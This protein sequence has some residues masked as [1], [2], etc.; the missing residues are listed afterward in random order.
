MA[1][2]QM[3]LTIDQLKQL[4]D[5]I[6][7]TDEG[8]L[9]VMNA[10][11][12]EVDQVSAM[13]SSFD[14]TMSKVASR[15]LGDI[16]S[17]KKA[18]D[19]FNKNQMKFQKEQYDLMK[20]IEKLQQIG[21]DE[22]ANAIVQ[23]RR[24]LDNLLN[25]SKQALEIEKKAYEEI[26]KKNLKVIKDFDDGI[27]DIKNNLDKAL[28][29]TN[30]FKKIQ[31]VGKE[32]KD[33]LDNAMQGNV[34]GMSR[35]LDSSLS[36]ITQVF[37]LKALKLA[38][39][40]QKDLERLAE[41][42]AG[43]AKKGGATEKDVEYTKLLSTKTSS[44]ASAQ[45]FLKLSKGL[46]VLSTGVMAVVSAFKMMI[47][48]EAKVKEFNRDMIDDAG[49]S[50]SFLRDS[51][52][53]LAESL[54]T[55][56]EGFASMANTVGMKASDIKAQFTALQDTTF[57][58]KERLKDF[59]GFEKSFTTL[60]TYSQ[61]LGLS[62]SDTTEMAE[63][64]AESLAIDVSTEKGMDTIS[65][66]FQDIGHYA[67]KT[68]ISTKAF[69]NQ[70]KEVNSKSNTFNKSIAQTSSIMFKLN[71][72]LGATTAKN[73]LEGM[74]DFK[75]KSQEDLIKMTAMAGGPA[76]K[77]MQKIAQSNAKVFASQ[78]QET[79]KGGKEQEVLSKATAG[80]GFKLDMSLPIDQL[81]DQFKNINLGSDEY[82]KFISQLR[83]EGEK[84]GMENIPE[85]IGKIEAVAKTTK[86]AG[87]TTYEEMLKSM[88]EFGMGATFA[89]QFESLKAIV[90]AKAGVGATL[91]QVTD[92]IV[93]NAIKEQ[94]GLDQKA[95]DALITIDQQARGDFLKAQEIQ[96]SYS[97]ASVDQQKEMDKQL[98]NMGLKMEQ[99]ADGSYALMT[100]Q[101]N[102]LV[103]SSKDMYIATGEIFGQQE[104]LKESSVKSEKELMAEQVDATWGLGDRL[105][106][107]LGVY[108]EQL[109]SYVARI[110]SYISSW[111]GSQ[112]DEEMKTQQRL[113]EEKILEQEKLQNEMKTERQRIADLNKKGKALTDQE[114]LQLE[115]SKEKYKALQDQSLAS[116]KS[117][118]LLKKGVE[119]KGTKFEQEQELATSTKKLGEL[120]YGKGSAGA[121][122]GALKES[123]NVSTN[124]QLLKT[125]DQMRD[126]FEQ[127]QEGEATEAQ[128]KLLEEFKKK[129]TDA[130]LELQLDETLLGTEY[131]KIKT[132]E[133]KDLFES[134][135]GYT[136]DTNVTPANLGATKS[137]Q[138][139]LSSF[140][141]DI[142]V[143]DEASL[144]AKLE[145]YRAIL[146][147]EN[148]LIFNSLTEEE[149]AKKTKLE[150]AFKKYGITSN[151]ES[152][153]TTSNLGLNMGGVD[154][155]STSAVSATGMQGFNT[156]TMNAQ[157]QANAKAQTEEDRRNEQATI[158]TTAKGVQKGLEQH[159]L[160]TMPIIPTTPAQDFIWREKGGI[161]TFSPQDNVIGFKDNGIMGQAVNNTIAGNTTN[162][163]TNN[164][165]SMINININGGNKD[166]IFKTIQDAL[167][168]AGVVTERNSYA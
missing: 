87:A 105:E 131:A 76:S 69:A 83:E 51:Q 31:Y 102:A 72:T 61:G 18:M 122:I 40:G 94:S 103:T 34:E 147:Q 44:D 77:Q 1:T 81:V 119:L 114:K 123:L 46:G 141:K 36:A 2:P 50:L 140:Y 79:F 35:V 80:T 143:S 62:I 9:K 53:S 88:K 128:I 136:S 100:K 104:K 164:T 21:R 42:E 6:S 45:G 148:D 115:E 28:T 33:T 126:I 152:G 158:D 109:N 165:R 150:D 97:S 23:K 27:D 63:S 24:E 48:A 149:Q 37:Q 85:L 159:Q 156:Q 3:Q 133:G 10:V 16:D 25:K 144:K 116:E 57:F 151:F 14:K 135:E 29:D 110:L 17:Q 60:R 101:T 12:Q 160:S 58:N 39:A 11:K 96:K 59:A 106:A 120:Q 19:S 52:E 64:F 55:Y 75:E 7:K 167:K 95:F 49:G 22:N 146:E 38:E 68:N 8:L 129:V 73:F 65:S 74:T 154:I 153:V 26:A 98:S 67:S 166:E 47:D 124:E 162:T 32:L 137:Q 168:R 161:Q 139:K 130:G 41:L 82:I 112:S 84:S 125:L 15:T 121:N 145:E 4:T 92:P 118:E 5:S 89:T 113:Q 117:L 86:G 111:F 78:L 66:A 90:E 43:G 13:R 127:Q 138:T 93:L 142:G 70:L 163:N 132:K 30:L 134:V 155:A 108:L 91:S 20:E 54:N 56:R 71:K 157:A 107:G 99:Q